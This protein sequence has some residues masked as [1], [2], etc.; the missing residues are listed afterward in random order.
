MK[1][2]IFKL[3]KESG[4]N[5]KILDI[6][7]TNK[8]DLN[9]PDESNT[10]LIQYAILFRN[11]EIVKALIDKKCKLDILDSDGRSLFYIPIKYTYIDIIELLINA[12]NL[13]VG[14]PLLELQDKYLNIPLHYAIH[15]NS[16]IIFEL[17]LNY[18]TNIN[19]KTNDGNTVLHLFIQ[20]TPKDKEFLA[21]KIIDKN[22]NINAKNNSGLNALHLAI[23]L[24]KY[25]IIK[26]L[27]NNNVDINIESDVM[28]NTPLII[29]THNNN[30]EIAKLL[31]KYNPNI[32][33]QDIYG[34]TVLNYAIINKY[35]ELIELYYNIID[36]NLI[37]IEGKSASYLFF[38][39]KYE[40]NQLNSY[41]F[42]EI[43]I[44][45]NINIQDIEGNT[46]WHYLIN[47]DIWEKYIDILINK[48][49][50][51]FIQNEKNISPYNLI[52][53]NY[54]NKL[55]NFI[56]LISHSFYN[57]IKNNSDIYKLNFNYKKISKK[58]CI[59][60]IKN[61]IINKHISTPI[62]KK[63]YIIKKLYIKSFTSTK[64]QFTYTG[65]NLDIIS[66]LI[67]LKK[68]FK[69]IQITLTKQFVHNEALEKYYHNNG[70][71]KENEFF[72]Y[73]FIWS[74]LKLFIPSNFKDII[75]NFL[76]SN[77]EYLIIPIGVELSNGSHANILIYD[78]TKNELERFEPHGSSYPSGF[79]YY[80]KILD[81][82][83]KS[84]FTYYLN[85]N[86]FKYFVPEN[87]EPKIGFQI[88]DILE[89]EYYKNITMT[90]PNGFCAAWCIW[91]IDMK[92]SN[93]S[94]PR[95][96]L[97][98]KLIN[99]IRLKNISF[100]TTIRNY[101]KKITDIRDNILKKN[102]LDINKWLY[103]NYTTK[104][105]NDIIKTINEF[106]I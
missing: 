104:E 30:L 92:L 42:K 53:N 66:G 83:I 4:N 20:N 78:K 7:S 22:V 67:F 1:K 26:I 29:A 25:H 99:Y 8:I 11:I 50:K 21:E 100:R 16:Y 103:N 102:N 47:S 93:I 87:F 48:K 13:I 49:N 18:S 57:L 32:N 94:I 62:K 85:D 65:I 76:S 70:I 28:H 58:E 41:Y 75:T 55:N 77:Y 51:I 35:N 82:Q 6:L 54:P 12:S 88:L 71:I 106:I 3:I 105:W 96:L 43:L 72:N 97:I 15:F 38:N 89:Y 98:P 39:N 45:S 33:Y 68:K 90:D 73:E 59:D 74:Y 60:K 86:K 56:E 34:N 40:Y 5:N 31:L 23:E 84:L 46:L 91:Y 95:D 44:K 64:Y 10:Y 61:L 69:N 14:I 101:T 17:I 19:F 24:N 52:I 36:V 27:L 37:N 80:P 63:S 9:E 79:N 2:L 81:I